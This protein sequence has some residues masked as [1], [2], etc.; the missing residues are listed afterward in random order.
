MVFTVGTGVLLLAALVGWIGSVWV[1]QMTHRY[2]YAIE[3]PGLVRHAAFFSALSWIPLLPLLLFS[4]IICADAA[5]RNRSLKIGVQSVGASFV[6]LTGYGTGFIRAWW[7]R[8]VQGKDEF[9][10]FEKSFYK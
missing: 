7:Q 2:V 9:S 5:V 4:V 1:F 8:C 6:Q 3:M 10:A